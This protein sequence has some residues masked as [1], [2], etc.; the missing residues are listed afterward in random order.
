MRTVVMQAS[1]VCLH[2]YS[3]LEPTHSTTLRIHKNHAVICWITPTLANTS[4]VTTPHTRIQLCA[5]KISIQTTVIMALGRITRAKAAEVAEK[6]HIDESAVLELPSEDVETCVDLASKTPEKDGR[7]P[8]GE[9]APNST[10]K[11]DDTEVADLRKSTKGR[12]GGKKGVKGKKTNLANS[13]A[14][15][16]EVAPEER[17]ETTT[18]DVFKGLFDCRSSDDTNVLS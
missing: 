11:E 5:G 7:A 12:K 9:I 3:Y 1:L 2:V 6:L 4:T 14:S 13:T 16:P 15:Q 10:G 8:L 17:E 18:E